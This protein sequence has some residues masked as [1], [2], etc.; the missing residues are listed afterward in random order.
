M[1][2][3]L[4]S[5]PSLTEVLEA[6]KD[7]LTPFGKN[8][9]NSIIKQLNVPLVSRSIRHQVENGM[10]MASAYQLALRKKGIKFGN[11]QEDA[12]EGIDWFF[13]ILNDFQPAMKLIRFRYSR[14]FYCDNCEE[15]A[16]PK[17]KIDHKETQHKM[18][19]IRKPPKSEDD[20][21]N[22]GHFIYNLVGGL[23]RYE[24]YKCSKCKVE[25]GG[26][27]I[28]TLRVL[29]E[30]MII[31][32]N[33]FFNKKTRYFPIQYR[34]KR[35]GKKEYLHYKLV[36]QIEHFGNRGGG[37]Y[38]VRVLRP[39]W[40]ASSGGTPSGGNGT[41]VWNI[42]DSDVKPSKFQMTK[43]TYLLIY[44]YFEPSDDDPYIQ[45]ESI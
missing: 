32:L 2:A 3:A 28:D 25:S 40:T 29:P 34:F 27:T 23:D 38:T 36:A 4:E 31:Q 35:K 33:Q 5:C 12:S 39:R 20:G 13:H 18:F 26:F 6:Y 7:D 21:T 14:E 11:K 19:N 22:Y 9:I 17:G 42:N 45:D 1:R 43:Y 41:Q 10:H 30:I 24:G 44:H 8:Y 15:L 16:L 37:H